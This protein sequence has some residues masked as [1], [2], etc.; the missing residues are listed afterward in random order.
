MLCRASHCGKAAQTVMVTDS[1]IGQ[2][3]AATTPAPS[4][5]T[6]SPAGQP[7]RT[8]LTA[9]LIGCADWI[10]IDDVNGDRQANILDVQWVAKR[11]FNVTPFVP[12]CP[13]HLT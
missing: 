3:E 1:L 10:E 2:N 6:H 12:V 5:E 11:A 4:P 7:A 13:P 9:T 8:R